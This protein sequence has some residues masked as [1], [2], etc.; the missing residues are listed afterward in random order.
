M[1]CSRAKNKESVPGFTL[2]ELLVTMGIIGLLASLLG[3][4][5]PAALKK[6]R[7]HK[8]STNLRSLGTALISFAGDHDGKLLLGAFSS[9]NSTLAGLSNYLGT[10]KILVC[11][12]DN[13]LIFSEG[14]DKLRVAAS[15]YPG[16]QNSNVSYFYSHPPEFGSRAILAGDRNLCYS[17]FPSPAGSIFTATYTIAQSNSYF[18]WNSF[19]HEFRGNVA[20]GDG[21]VRL[22]TSDAIHQ[23]MSGQ[24]L[25][26][27]NKVTINSPN[28]VP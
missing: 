27:G 16:L 5:L 26:P 21:S 1:N 8:C 6:A 12:A 22:T 7:T 23:A 24:P 17:S 9:P 28:D 25:W 13:Q 10:P 2:V 14:T 15:A 4:T 18:G 19:L 20:M 11:P 3:A